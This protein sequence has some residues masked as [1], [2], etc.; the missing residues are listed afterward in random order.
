MVPDVETTAL[1]TVVSGAL[2]RLQNDADGPVRYDNNRKIWIYLH[3]DKSLKQLNSMPAD[4]AKQQRQRQK[5]K[6]KV[7]TSLHKPSNDD[8]SA[9]VQ[10]IIVKDADGNVIPLSQETLQR[11]ISSGALKATT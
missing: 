3:R 10:K 7:D 4:G 1:T 8:Q 9:S 5:R 2:D 6:F 11:L